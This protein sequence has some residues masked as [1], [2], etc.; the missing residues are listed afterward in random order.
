[1][2]DE[3]MVEKRETKKKRKRKKNRPARG[4]ERKGF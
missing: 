1:M 3:E 4:K 2:A